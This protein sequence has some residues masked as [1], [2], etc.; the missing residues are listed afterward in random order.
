MSETSLFPSPGHLN[1]HNSGIRAAS[2]GRDAREDA[3]SEEVRL[4]GGEERLDACLPVSCGKKS[5][6]QSLAAQRELL[7][8]C[9]K[10]AYGTSVGEG[11]HDVAR[12]PPLLGNTTCR[13][14]LERLRDRG[15]RCQDD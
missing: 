5:I 2:P 14:H 8:P 7:Q 10:L 11:L 6:Q 13:V 1:Q 4:V 15:A 9:E 12:R 3:E